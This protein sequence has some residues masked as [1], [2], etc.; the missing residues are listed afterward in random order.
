MKSKLFFLLVLL[1]TQLTTFAQNNEPFPGTT[2]YYYLSFN[3]RNAI[4]ITTNHPIFHIP[5]T[6]PIVCISSHTLYLLEGCDNTLLTIIDNNDNIV[7]LNYLSS[8]T[9]VI[10]LPSNLIG[11]YK[12]QITRGNNI[13]YTD[14]EF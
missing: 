9:T 7:F 10:Q 1:V 4:D 13:F 6:P 3:V 12:L 5:P 8:N 14:I 2:N 11:P